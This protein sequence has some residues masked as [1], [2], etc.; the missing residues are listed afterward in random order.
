MLNLDGKV[1]SSLKRHLFGWM[2][3]WYRNGLLG[4]LLLTG[5]YLYVCVCLWQGWSQQ[6][7]RSRTHLPPPPPPHPNPVFPSLLPVRISIRNS[8]IKPPL[9]HFS[10]RS[11]LFSEVKYYLCKILCVKNHLLLP[12]FVILVECLPM[13]FTLV[14]R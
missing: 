8:S 13:V 6:F 5:S 10:L 4:C 11:N 2:V 14:G 1:A 12:F 9:S 3:L 7:F